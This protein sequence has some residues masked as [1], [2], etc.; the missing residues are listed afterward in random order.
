MQLLIIGKALILLIVANG[1]PVVLN[2]ILGRDYSRSIDGGRRF[3]DG[4]PLLGASKTF[5]GLL[6]SLLATSLFAPLLGISWVTGALFA[7]LAMVGDL[8]SSFLKRRLGMA[9]SSKAIGLDQIPESLVPLLVC[10][11]QLGLSALDIVVCVIAFI[12]LELSFSPI[13][14]WLGLKNRPY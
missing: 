13:F 8:F 2:S 14:Y 3:L 12:V 4:R 10:D 11:S 6:A 1:I 9:S 7:L 5:S